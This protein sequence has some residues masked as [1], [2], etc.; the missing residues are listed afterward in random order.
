MKKI[1]SAYVYLLVLVMRVRALGI[2]VYGV[3]RFSPGLALP[4]CS[5][6]CIEPARRLASRQSPVATRHSSRFP[7]WNV[8][9][10]K[11]P[12]SKGEGVGGDGHAAAR[13]ESTGLGRV[14]RSG[15][16]ARTPRPPYVARFFA[17]FN[18]ESRASSE[19]R[20]RAG[21]REDGVAARACRRVVQRPAPT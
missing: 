13:L 18:A 21:Y 15:R 4:V 2:P 5:L 14:I 9:S 17:P 10:R 11:A 12:L 19:R 20:P 6:Y 7:S 3:R 1:S 8:D 16:N